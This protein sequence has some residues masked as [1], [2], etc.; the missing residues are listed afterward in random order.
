[1]SHTT[2]VTQD[3]ADAGLNYSSKSLSSSSDSELSSYKMKPKHKSEKN[4]KLQRTHGGI[5]NTVKISK[6]SFLPFLLPLVISM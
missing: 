4:K 3:T 5:D 2:P 6:F 1:M